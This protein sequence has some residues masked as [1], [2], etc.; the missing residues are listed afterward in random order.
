MNGVYEGVL[1]FVL[2]CNIEVGHGIGSW[3]AET[4]PVDWDDM[5]GKPDTRVI[6]RYER[7]HGFGKGRG[8]EEEECREPVVSHGYKRSAKDV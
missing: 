4:L 5:P 3:V 6:P 8:G 2:E 7:R 1:P